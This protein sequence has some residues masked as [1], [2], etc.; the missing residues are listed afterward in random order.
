MQT[1]F[2]EFFLCNEITDS[3]FP[4]PVFHIENPKLYK[5]V[6]MVAVQIAEDRE[7]CTV[8]INL[9]QKYL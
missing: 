2:G 5:N 6:T 3:F 7:I 1:H 4:S 9:F 8:M